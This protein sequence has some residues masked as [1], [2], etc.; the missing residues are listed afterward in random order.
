MRKLPK[1]KIVLSTVKSN[2][3]DCIFTALKI[4]EEIGSINLDLNRGSLSF[5]N[6]K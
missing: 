1:F 3:A 6:G 2:F 4:C 5:K